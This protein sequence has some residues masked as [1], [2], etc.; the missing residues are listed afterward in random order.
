M[1]LAAHELAS[2]IAGSN[3]PARLLSAGS[4]GDTLRVA[5]GGHWPW[6]AWSGRWSEGYGFPNLPER[7]NGMTRL[8]LPGRVVASALAAAALA[9]GGC[10]KPTP[11][12]EPQERF[13]ELLSRRASPE[14]IC[15]V[16][17]EGL[18]N[19]SELNAR[20]QYNQWSSRVVLY[21]DNGPPPTGG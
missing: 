12:H 15:E 2:F 5:V 11:L 17:R 6:M 3:E 13:D 16:A 18:R 7:G 14:Q 10:H 20:P 21:C 1:G 4:P 8:N 9:T 19:A